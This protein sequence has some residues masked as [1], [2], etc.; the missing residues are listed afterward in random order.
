MAAPAPKVDR[1]TA[2]DVE[3]QLY[4]LL[5]LYTARWPQFDPRRGA[6]AAL[7]GVSKRYAEIIIERLNN[8]P[9]KNFLAFLDLLGASLLAPQPARVPLTF[10]LAAGTLTDAVVPAGTQAAAPPAEGEKAPVIF[11]TERELVVTAARLEAVYV[12]DPERDR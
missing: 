5:K 4:Q 7:V 12:R 10:S 3:Q 11:E 9:E 6:S 2:A 1:R 8:V